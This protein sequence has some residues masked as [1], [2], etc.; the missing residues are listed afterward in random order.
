MLKSI[1]ILSLSLLFVVLYLKIESRENRINR[2]YQF[3]KMISE[4]M[5]IKNISND[6]TIK[7]EMKTDLGFSTQPYSN[8]W[9]RLNLKKPINED[10]VYFKEVIPSAEYI[11][12]EKKEGEWKQLEFKKRNNRLYKY[13]IDFDEKIEKEIFILAKSFRQR[14]IFQILDEKGSEIF[15]LWESALLGFMFGSLFSFFISNLILRLRAI[16]KSYDYYLLSI[17]LVFFNII[18]T[19][20]ILEQLIEYY[21]LELSLHLMRMAYLLG[22]VGYIMF[23]QN[24]IKLATY[25]PRLNRFYNYYLI[26]ILISCILYSFNL[27]DRNLFY[28]IARIYILPIVTI[29]TI[30]ATLYLWKKKLI[31]EAKFIFQ[32]YL[33]LA[34]VVIQQTLATMGIIRMDFLSI[35]GAG[36]TTCIQLYLFSLALEF[37]I[38]SLNEEKKL[39]E[40]GNQM[41]DA[42]VSIISHDLKTPLIGVFNLLNILSNKEIAK[43]EKEKDDLL[44]LCAKSIRSSISM[45]KELIDTSKINTGKLILSKTNESIVELLDEVLSDLQTS[46]LHKN[47][48]IKNQISYL[49][50]ISID[51]NIFNHALKNII[52]NAIKYSFPNGEIEISN[53]DSKYESTIYITDFGLGMNL[54]T[55]EE[56]NKD[57][58]GNSQMGTLQEVGTG[59]G[60]F[61]SKYILDAH[62]GRMEFESIEGKKTICKIILPK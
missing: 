32:S 62:Q 42:F 39:A 16:E 49:T 19:S 4:E 18:I 12:Y 45:I 48:L 11:F 34:I 55:I 59:L 6:V 20:G 47:I 36:L 40:D 30:L 35:Y 38:R 57:T 15:S 43:T 41:K 14:I 27:L 17:V 2:E 46:I 24:F 58:I 52:S 54:K 33:I 13:K 7:W 56:I 29:I 3:T 5:N 61:I 50:K 28:L 44:E 60:L 22:P 51:K 31:Q 26:A 9:I 23:M 8:Y 1:L 21:N 25:S 53:S 37:R 10:Y